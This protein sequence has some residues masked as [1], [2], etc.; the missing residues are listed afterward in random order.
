MASNRRYARLK[1]ALSVSFG[2][3]LG[4]FLDGVP[5]EVEPFVGVEGEV[6]SALGEFLFVGGGCV[7]QGLGAYFF[8]GFAPL[9]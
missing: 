1:Q 5:D 7:F 6:D 8:A 3:F 9:L 4:V 2:G